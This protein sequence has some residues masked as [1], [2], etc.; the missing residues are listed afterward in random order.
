MWTCKQVARGL[1]E[2]HYDD[3]PKWK[4][5]GLKVHVA[6]CVIC[7]RYHKDVML[8]QDCARALSEREQ[9]GSCQLPASLA[10][11][12]KARMKKQLQDAD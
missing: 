10:D 11:D 9:E 8:M 7:R 4:R 12:A 3:L 1:A 5:I 2:K 6:L